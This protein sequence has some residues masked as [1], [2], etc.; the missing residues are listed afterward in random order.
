MNSLRVQHLIINQLAAERKNIF[1]LLCFKAFYLLFKAAI[2]TL[3]AFLFT[4]HSWWRAKIIHRRCPT[5][6]RSLE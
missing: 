6:K 4:K 3:F 1:L 5:H 2:G